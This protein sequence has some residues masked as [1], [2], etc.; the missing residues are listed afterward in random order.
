MSTFPAIAGPYLS[1]RKIRQDSAN[2]ERLFRAH[3]GMSTATCE[4]VWQEL[5]PSNLHHTI[6]KKHLLW[7][8]FYLKVYSSIDVSASK[9]GVTAPTWRKWVELTLDSLSELNVIHWNDR[10]E[11]WHSL[12]P[13][14]YV[15]GV[16]CYAEERRPMYRGDYSHKLNHAGWAFEVATALG[17]SK[18]VHIAGGVPAGDWPDLKLARETLVPRLLPNEKVAADKGYREQQ[19]NGNFITPVVNRQ[20]DPAVDAHNRVLKRM[21]A[22]HETV[23]KRI[24][25]FQILKT[26]RGEREKFP[27]IFKVVAN[28]TQIKMRSEPLYSF[29]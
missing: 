23:N 21:G 13:S 14:C 25:D 9:F 18:I 22:R 19:G 11:N 15:D 24:K 2:F 1:R 27:K 10:F 20:N 12:L 8:L 4:E 5:I 16:H 29:Q 28:L 26:Y 17:T 7:T 6:E 3:F